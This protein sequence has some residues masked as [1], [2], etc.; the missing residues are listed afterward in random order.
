MD[1]IWNPAMKQG[2]LRSAQLFGA[3]GPSRLPMLDRF[4]AFPGQFETGWIVQ[5]LRKSRSAGTAVSQIRSAGH[6]DLD[7]L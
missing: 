4:G 6:A 3:P 7:M 5:L 2:I 1:S